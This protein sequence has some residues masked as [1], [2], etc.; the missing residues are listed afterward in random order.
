M[1][2]KRKELKKGYKRCTKKLKRTYKTKGTPQYM[3]SS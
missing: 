3:I 2:D 1:N